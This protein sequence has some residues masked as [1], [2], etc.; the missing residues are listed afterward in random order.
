MSVLP[1]LIVNQ[2]EENFVFH[3]IDYMGISLWLVGFS[4]EVI[5]DYQKITWQKLVGNKNKFINTG[6]WTV[7]RHP[8]YFGEILLWIG[9][10]LSAFAGTSGLKSL[11]VFLSPISVAFLLV[12]IS[13]VPLL[14]KKTNEE[15]GK[16]E[17]YQRYKKSTPVLIPFIGRVGDASF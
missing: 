9:I 3:L 7:S 12:Y 11:I 2:S 14:E 10:A 13:G 15:F 16:D 8:N 6:L 4:I 1:V 17:A 5:A